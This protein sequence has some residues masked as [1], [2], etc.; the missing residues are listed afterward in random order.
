MF[1][2]IYEIKERK[3]KQTKFERRGSVMTADRRSVYSKGDTT[4]WIDE[5]DA[6]TE[7]I[8]DTMP[9]YHKKNY[10]RDAMKLC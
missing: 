9:T 7:I 3:Q 6:I 4:N 2:Q 5:L 8:N 1:T 10:P